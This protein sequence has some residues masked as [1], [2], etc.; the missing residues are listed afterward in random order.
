M[1]VLQCPALHCWPKLARV[2][3]VWVLPCALSVGDTCVVSPRSPKLTLWVAGLVCACFGSLNPPLA[4][5]GCVRLLVSLPG[6]FVAGLQCSS[7]GCAVRVIC[8]AQVCM[9][10]LSRHSS[11]SLCAMRVV[12]APGVRM[13]RHTGLPGPALCPARVVCSGWVSMPPQSQ[14]PRLPSGW[15]H[16]L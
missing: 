15:G 5:P 2:M 12:C 4:S 10:P 13:P 16:S 8:V 3:P 11:P 6:L 14:F 9:P 1:L 7:F